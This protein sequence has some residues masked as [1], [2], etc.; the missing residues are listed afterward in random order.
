MCERSARVLV[1][2]DE[3]LLARAIVLIL[4]GQHEVVV[5]HSV[6]EAESRLRSDG[7]FDAVLCDMMLPD[8]LGMDLFEDV[9][10]RDPEQARRFVFLTGGVTDARVAEFLQRVDNPRLSKPFMPA[11]LRTVVEAITAVDP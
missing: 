3:P 2:D 9:E 5:V 7:P 4:R 8:R 11:E 1:V 10:A 6:A